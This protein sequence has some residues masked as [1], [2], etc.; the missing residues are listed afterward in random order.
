MSVDELDRSRC[1]CRLVRRLLLVV[2][3]AVDVDELF[4]ADEARVCS[5]DR[6]RCR[7]IK[8]CVWCC[9]TNMWPTAE[10]HPPPLFGVNGEEA[11]GNVP[12]D[13]DPRVASICVCSVDTEVEIEDA[14]DGRFSVPATCR[15][16][17]SA[18]PLLLSSFSSSLLFGI[19]PLV[20]VVVAEGMWV[21]NFSA[22]DGLSATEE[23]F[24]SVRFRGH[25]KSRNNAKIIINVAIISPRTS[26]R[27]LHYIGGRLVLLLVGVSASA[28][29][30]RGKY[31]AL[32]LVLL[33]L[34]RILV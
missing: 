14:S 29:V 2:V 22:D 8:C 30:F 24:A 15:L 34:L 5:E 31:I 26:T 7:C 19:L 12:E 16:E 10:T 6:D 27:P 11:D 13:V 3:V 4:R 9:D 25:R 23:E 21:G 33:L 18:W 28:M 32:C 1:S 17:L 20:V